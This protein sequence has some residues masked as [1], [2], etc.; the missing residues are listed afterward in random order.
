MH[1]LTIAK[2]RR[3]FQLFI[4]RWHIWICNNIQYFC[5]ISTLFQL[6]LIAS[7][8][9]SPF[10]CFW[11][12]Q[13]TYLPT[14]I[15]PTL[16]KEL[17][18]FHGS[19]RLHVTTAVTLHQFFSAGMA[20]SLSPLQSIYSL[21]NPCKIEINKV[22]GLLAFISSK[23]IQLFFTTTKRKMSLLF[24]ESLQYQNGQNN[25]YFKKFLLSICNTLKVIQSNNFFFRSI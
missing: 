9:I 17:A 22:Y 21:S 12:L 10:Q 4:K 6:K 13:S 3:F 8:N 19:L 15:G 16:A 23:K 5:D 1:F 11:P 7:N 25:F 20:L 2:A 24:S 18:Q 14:N